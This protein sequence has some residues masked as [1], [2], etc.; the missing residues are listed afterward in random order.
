MNSQT[1][2]A[3][4]QVVPLQEVKG[5]IETLLAHFAEDLWRWWEEDS[6][7]AIEVLFA[8]LDAGV[9][10]I[11]LYHTKDKVRIYKSGL[12]FVVSDSHHSS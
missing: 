11:D 3:V 9:G 4:D 12:G 10:Q 8:Q 7:K 6:G 5:I 1:S 2:C